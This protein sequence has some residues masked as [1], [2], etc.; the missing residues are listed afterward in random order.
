MWSQVPATDKTRRLLCSEQSVTFYK[1]EDRN[2][3][4]IIICVLIYKEPLD[5]WYI[6]VNWLCQP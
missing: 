2:K 6:L 3:I 4:V 5:L 1:K